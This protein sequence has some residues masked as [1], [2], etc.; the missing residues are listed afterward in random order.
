M[1]YWGQMWTRIWNDLAVVEHSRCR[2]GRLN[3]RGA[4]INFSKPR[5]TDANLDT[6][7]VL[8]IRVLKNTFGGVVAGKLNVA[9]TQGLSGAL[10]PG[11][12]RPLNGAVE[13][14]VASE[15]DR[16][17]GGT[18]LGHNDAFRGICR[19]DGRGLNVAGSLHC[20]GARGWTLIAVEH[21]T[22]SRCGPCLTSA[23]QGIFFYQ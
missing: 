3:L 16:G 17:H 6:F 22:R 11:D 1:L 13:T 20:R 19:R 4:R 7:D 9:M 12:V 5:R 15:V 23:T 14:E 21:F 18:K 8:F 2:M 10:I